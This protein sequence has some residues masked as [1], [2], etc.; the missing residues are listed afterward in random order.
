MHNAKVT[1]CEINIFDLSLRVQLGD[2]CSPVRWNAFPVDERKEK[3]FYTI[4]G[5]TWHVRPI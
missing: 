3:L 4:N 1:N 2:K 5:M